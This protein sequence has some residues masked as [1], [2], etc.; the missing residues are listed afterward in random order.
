VIIP[1]RF[2]EALG[3]WLGGVIAPAFA[4]GSALRR[5][6]VFHPRGIT[7]RAE[8]KAHAAVNPAFAK[9]AAG[10]SEGDALVRLSTGLWRSD[11]SFAP[12]LLGFAIRFHT[13]ANA[14]FQAQQGSQDLLLATSPSLLALP[15]ALL[16]TNQRDFLANRYFGMSPF[17]VAGQPNMYLRIVPMTQV[18][19]PGAN[20][21]E[22]IRNA[23]ADNEIVF[24][25]EIASA[26]Q[27]T[28]WHPLVEI[29]L[30]SEVMVDQ[31]ALKLWPFQVGQGIRPQ[32]LTQFMRPV[33]Y[34]LSQYARSM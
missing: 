31:S 12:D 26:S 23:V 9:L 17:E 4:V 8:V 7:F 2:S 3:L 10:L 13:N 21:Y 25:L 30:T 32:G 24:R 20:R 15:I 6:R 28:Q 33:P 27:T 11:R 1:N 34:L 19:A 14:N 18:N 29:R 5:G 16:V 22:R